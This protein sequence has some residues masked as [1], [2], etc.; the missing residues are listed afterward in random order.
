MKSKDKEEFKKF[1]EFYEKIRFE[2]LSNQLYSVIANFIKID[3]ESSKEKA[4]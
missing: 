3:K 2:S 1:V 4:R